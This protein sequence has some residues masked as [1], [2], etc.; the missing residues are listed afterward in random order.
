MPFVSKVQVKK[1]FANQRRNPSTTW[2]CKEWAAKTP[3]LKA[4]PE[5][6]QPPRSD[7]PKPRPNRRK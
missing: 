1:C 7:P 4:L 3:S 6:L 5:R 2:D